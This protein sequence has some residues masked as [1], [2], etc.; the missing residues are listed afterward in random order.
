VEKDWLV[1]P[2]KYGKIMGNELEF[3]IVEYVKLDVF[4]VME[5]V[6]LTNPA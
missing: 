2:D 1:S 3:T 4:E 5:S 6:T